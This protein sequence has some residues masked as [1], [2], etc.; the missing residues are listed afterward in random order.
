MATLRDEQLRALRFL[1]RHPGGCTEAT[2]L[3]QGFTAVQL[4]YLA[5]LQD[6]GG[7]AI[8]QTPKTTSTTANVSSGT[9]MVAPSEQVVPAADGEGRNRDR[10]FGEEQRQDS[11]PA[12]GEYT[13]QAR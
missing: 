8:S 13:T 4:G 2:L 12:E 7:S 1:A 3:K 11:I 9:V 10:L 6:T 5:R